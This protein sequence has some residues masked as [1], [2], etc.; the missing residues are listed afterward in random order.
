[1]SLLAYK[2]SGKSDNPFPSYRP[3]SLAKHCDFKT[4]LFGLAM[5][6]SAKTEH[7]R[8]LVDPYL[9]SN[10]CLNKHHKKLYFRKLRQFK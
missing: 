8:R 9:L 5:F 1:M 6:G 3:Q 4:E 7:V 10:V 2:I